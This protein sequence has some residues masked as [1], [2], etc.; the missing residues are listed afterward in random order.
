VLLQLL[1][2]ISQPDLQE[3]GTS[4]AL[5]VSLEQHFILYGVTKA[6]LV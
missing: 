4:M 5:L 3:E 1:L 6:H 2:K